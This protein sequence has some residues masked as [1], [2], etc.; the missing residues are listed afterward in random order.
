MDFLCTI[1]ATEHKKNFEQQHKLGTNFIM[2][3]F[4]VYTDILIKPKLCWNLDSC[5]NKKFL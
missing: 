1:K 2:N 4:G 5:K 3:H